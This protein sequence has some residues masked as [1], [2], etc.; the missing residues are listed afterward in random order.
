MLN[1]GSITYKYNNKISGPFI[2]FDDDGYILE[3][4]YIKNSIYKDVSI[5]F[6]PKSLDISKINYY[7]DSNIGYLSHPLPE[8]YFKEDREALYQEYMKNKN[9]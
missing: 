6:F 3:Y 8:G 7:L 9:K 1:I 4:S 5:E 2:V